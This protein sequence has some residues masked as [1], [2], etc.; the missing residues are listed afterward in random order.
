MV[1]PEIMCQIPHHA[2]IKIIPPVAMS[3]GKILGLKS[4]T[5]PKPAF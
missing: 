4:N 2:V 1:N 5:K 3:G